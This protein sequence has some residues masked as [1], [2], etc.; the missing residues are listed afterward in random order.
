MSSW[1]WRWSLFLVSCPVEGFGISHTHNEALFLLPWTFLHWFFFSGKWI[2]CLQGQ[3]VQTETEEHEGDYRYFIDGV[4]IF[5]LLFILYYYFKGLCFGMSRFSANF[6]DV[7]K[8]YVGWILSDLQRERESYSQ[9]CVNILQIYG[10]L[11]LFFCLQQEKNDQFW[12]VSKL[13]LVKSLRS[14]KSAY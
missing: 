12:S 13:W 10:F 3:R 2:Q 1:R 6:D 8:P 4:D 5:R 11:S 14:C 7:Y 9:K